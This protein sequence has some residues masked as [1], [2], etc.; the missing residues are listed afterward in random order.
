MCPALHIEAV[1]HVLPW[2]C[3]NAEV[4]VQWLLGWRRTCVEVEAH[5][6]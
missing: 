6:C 1:V 2:R 3:T 5:V 4:R